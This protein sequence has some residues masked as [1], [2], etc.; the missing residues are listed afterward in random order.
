MCVRGS[1]CTVKTFHRHWVQD[2]NLHR[3]STYDATVITV[4]GA[5]RSKCRFS[6]SLD[7]SFWRSCCSPSYL[8]CCSCRILVVSLPH[9]WWWRRLFRGAETICWQQLCFTGFVTEIQGQ[10][11]GSFWMDG[12]FHLHLSSHIAMCVVISLKQRTRAM[13]AHH[14]GEATDCYTRLQ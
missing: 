9:S 13:Y 12:I 2:I 14:A 8:Q 11:T 10:I 4:R 5:H 1:S 6:S 7:I 3:F